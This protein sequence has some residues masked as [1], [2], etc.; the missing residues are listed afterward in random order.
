MNFLESKE[1]V[2]VLAIVTI[3]LLVFNSFAIMGVNSSMSQQ[4]EMLKFMQNNSAS[5][6][7]STNTGNSASQD[8]TNSVL[9]FEEF[10]PKGTPAVY[11]VNLGV[12]FDDPVASLDVLAALDGDLYQEGQIKF[13]DLSEEEQQSYIRIGTSISCEFCCGVEYVTAP[14]GQPACGCAHS[15]AMRGLAKYLVQNHRS[16]FSDEEILEQLTMWK[17]MFFPKQMYQRALEFQ[18]NGSSQES[19]ALGEIPDMVGGC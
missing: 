16:E 5:L 11:G 18:S 13:S 4:N 17:A 9:S 7:Q 12:S 15:A 2:L 8:T 14:N 19:D 6:T 3:G 10:L 1:L